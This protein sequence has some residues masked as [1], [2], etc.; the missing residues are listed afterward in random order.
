MSS[1]LETD[2]VLLAESKLRAGDLPEAL[3]EHLPEPLRA[4]FKCVRGLQQVGIELSKPVGSADIKA[5][6]GALKDVHADNP[7]LA[8]RVRDA[9]A[10]AV[11]RKGQPQ[12]AGQ[13]RNIELVTPDP[14]IPAGVTDLPP[15]HAPGTGQ[16]G[17]RESV[18][19]GLDDLG[20]EVHAEARGAERK[21]TRSLEDWADFRYTLGHGYSKLAV[22]R[23]PSNQDKDRDDTQVAL[24]RKQQRQQCLPLVAGTLGRKLRP[25]ER[26][27]VADMVAR[28]YTNEQIVAELKRID[29]DRP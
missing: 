16:A 28:G 2:S 5:L 10:A 24:R 27:L 17:Q 25:S 15:P 11:E 7:K 29:E 8:A 22:A 12:L 6:T 21:F 4:Q 9:A 13:L 19:K 20:P 1:L 26:L 14:P 3:V 23:L 18:L